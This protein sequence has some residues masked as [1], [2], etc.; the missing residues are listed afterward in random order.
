[1]SPPVELTRKHPTTASVH[2]V[3][4]TFE[5]I[6]A[7]LDRYVL[8][9]GQLI[10]PA[11]CSARRDD[12]MIYYHAPDGDFVEIQIDNF[13]TPAD[14][15]NYMR[16]PEYANDSVGPAFDPKAM[17]SARCGGASVEELVGRAWSLQAGLPDPMSILVGA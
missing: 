6:D 10:T 12:D 9:R 3:G 11:V 16:G 8:L 14:A 2:H 1:M 13:A 4:H 5:N 7:L 17:L 15:T